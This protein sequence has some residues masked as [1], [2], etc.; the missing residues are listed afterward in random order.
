MHEV[1]PCSFQ[2]LLIF[3]F[4]SLEVPSHSPMTIFAFL[5]VRPHI[6]VLL[7]ALELPVFA[8][9][10]IRGKSQNSLT[11]HFLSEILVAQISKVRIVPFLH[12]SSQT[13]YLFIKIYTLDAPCPRTSYSR[14]LSLANSTYLLLPI[15]LDW[16]T[17][18]SQSYPIPQPSPLLST[19]SLPTSASLPRS[20]YL[21]ISSSS[22]NQSTSINLPGSVL[23]LSLKLFL[24]SAS[25]HPSASSISINI[26][27][28]I[29]L[30][31]SHLCPLLLLPILARLSIRVPV[32]SCN[33]NLHHHHHESFIR[34]RIFMFSP[35]A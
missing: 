7:P 11:I 31:S 33:P 23:F 18:T 19:S 34:G 4:R 20:A 27:I 9:T 17:S 13:L 22:P 1:R 14:N 32:F 2:N 10:L 12:T 35:H 21:S 30:H 16:V 29:S 8:C 25:P 6:P 5:A 3:L 28:S 15:H 24:F 26:S